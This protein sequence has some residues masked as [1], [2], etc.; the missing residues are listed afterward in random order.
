LAQ[1]FK[2][3]VVSHC[4]LPVPAAMVRPQFLL[5]F[6]PVAA[7]S[8]DG[9]VPKCTNLLSGVAASG[10]SDVEVAA[11]CRQAYT[12]SMCKSMR[13]SLGAMPWPEAKIE[14]SCKQWGGDLVARSDRDLMTYEDFNNMLETSAETKKSMGYNMPLNAD[15]SVDLDKTIS[16]KWEQTQ[17]V[18]RAYNAYYVDE[19]QATPPPTNQNFFGKWSAGR[20]A[21]GAGG[22][23]TTA[24]ACS[25]AAF[26]ALIVGASV[27]FVRWVRPSRA[28][29]QEDTLL[30]ES[31]E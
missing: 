10:H 8:Q 14:S 24:A 16:Q 30:D 27:G 11:F 21:F 20:V 23:S 12:P 5:L 22:F 19:E 6:A 7:V 13:S 29:P 17:V 25:L 15:G 9:F 3:K 31:I 28:A 1:T 26:F 2:E 18:V 4:L